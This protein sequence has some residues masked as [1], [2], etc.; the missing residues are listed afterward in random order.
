MGNRRSGRL[1]PAPSERDHSL[2]PADAPVTLVEYGD[3]QCPYCRQA[4]PILRK[5]RK[6]FEGRLRFVFRNFPLTRQHPEAQHAAEAAESVAA[7][8]GSD[9]F[10]K[11]HD[12]IY[13]HQ[14]DSADALD[15]AHL[16]AYAAAAGG[17]AAQVLDDLAAGTFAERVREDFL[18]GVHSGVNGTPTFY[19]NG[20]RFDG[21]W[22]D[23]EEFA[24]AI[25]EAAPS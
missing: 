17:S 18:S 6:R 12:A 19:I 15:D 8:A 13:T 20:V 23:V 16:A 2:G 9:A 10:W 1:E 25:D 11:M 3:Y 21:A 4:H 7:H 5:L 14:Q 24:L 22:T